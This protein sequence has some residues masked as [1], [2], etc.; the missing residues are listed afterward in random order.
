MFFFN[1]SVAI[2]VAIK[3]LAYRQMVQEAR[4]MTNASVRECFR[5]FPGLEAL[6]INNQGDITRLVNDMLEDIEHRRL[7]RIVDGMEVQ[8]SN[9]IAGRETRS[10]RAWE[11]YAMGTLRVRRAPTGNTVTA[12]NRYVDP[13][14]RIDDEQ[15]SEPPGRMTGGPGP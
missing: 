13:M 4:P 10:V 14:L 7:D 12:G 6:F 11:R 1:H 3:I 15:G 8:Q 5:L 9:L 2:S